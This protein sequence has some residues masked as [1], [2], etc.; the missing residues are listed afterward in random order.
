MKGMEMPAALPVEVYLNEGQK[1]L[2]NQFANE[3]WT[4]LIG[5]YAGDEV[6]PEHYSADI[7]DLQV[8]NVLYETHG[9]HGDV[10]RD[11]GLAKVGFSGIIASAAV[12]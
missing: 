7:E 3:N 1:A 10:P 2:L 12:W 8:A 4:G 6:K 9:G 5:V 11:N